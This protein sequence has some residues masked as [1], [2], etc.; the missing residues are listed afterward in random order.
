MAKEKKKISFSLKLAIFIMMVT[1]VIF[2][3]T[4]IVL[5]VCLIPS[6]VAAIVDNYPQKTAGI[7]VGMMN[8]AGTVPIVVKLWSIGHNLPVALQLVTE[9]ETILVSY[10]AAAVG[11]GIYNYITPFVAGLVALKNERR[12]REIEKRQKELIRKWGDQVVTKS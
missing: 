9:A 12:L 5:G 2:L 1:G 8:M 4:T 11:W 7:T 6:F 3:P 10:G